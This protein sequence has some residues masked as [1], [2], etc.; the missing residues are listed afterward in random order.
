MPA[1][2]KDFPWMS[3]YGNYKFFEEKI[4][5]HSKVCALHNIGDGYY[6]INLSE[7]RVIRVFIC[8][9]YSFGMA[10]YIES[11][12]KLG[13][14]QVIIINSNWCGYAAEAKRYCR[15]HGVGLFTIGEFMAALNMDKFWE[16]L[17]KQ[18]TEY[19]I[20]NGWL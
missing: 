9:C 1:H 14:I 15:E 13:K 18:E 6:E 17:T 16:Y 2:N 19:F 20:K 11:V 7:E 5:S 4:R 8:E 12:E 10:E 3:Y